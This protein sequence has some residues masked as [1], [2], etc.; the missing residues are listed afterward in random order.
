MKVINFE[1]H[2]CEKVRAYLDSYLNNELLVETTHDVLRHLE[3]C[4]TCSDALENRR[5]V[6]AML[7]A[8]V[9]KETASPALED[10]IRRRIRKNPARGW[11]MWTLAAAAAVILIAVGLI[12][13]RVWIHTSATR[14]IAQTGGAQLL[15]VGLKD[16]VH[17]TIDS[18]FA[19]REFTEAEMRERLGPEF[20]GLVAAVNDKLPGAYRVTVGHR[21]KANGREYVHLVLKSGQTAMSLVIT[22][23]NNE[24]FAASHVAAILQSAGV[25]LYDARLNNL[26]VVGFETPDYLAFIVSDLGREENLQ[27]AASLAPPVEAFLSKLNA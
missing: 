13:W 24:S 8:A 23:K 14:T 4:D 2:H 9:M 1:P 5:R 3:Q 6:K 16:H 20:F 22:K 11:P 7:K 25:P 12:G 18:G 10:R 19:N 27:V 26:E 15:E 17:C 21:C